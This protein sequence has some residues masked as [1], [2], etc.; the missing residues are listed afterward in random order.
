MRGHSRFQLRKT[1]ASFRRLRCLALLRQNCDFWD[2]LAAKC[3]VHREPVLLETGRTIRN[4][5][6]S[7]ICRVWATR[8]GG[9]CRLWPLGIVPAGP[10]RV[11]SVLG[12]RHPPA[13]ENLHGGRTTTD[14][15]GLISG[16]GRAGIRRVPHVK[17]RA[18]HAMPEDEKW[19]QV[20]WRRGNERAPGPA[21]CNHACA[22]PMERRSAQS[23]APAP[24]TWPARSR[25]A[26]SATKRIRE[27]LGLDRFERRGQHRRT[28]MTVMAY[29]LNADAPAGATQAH[30]LPV[31]TMT[32]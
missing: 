4:G 23:A 2:S 30:S 20:S 14:L 32:R 27:E 6:E 9:G 3:V 18:A 24:S 5:G 25:R 7:R 26:G 8:H 22:L 15:P 16:F 19:R 28:L 29:A 11:E 21:L 12:R 17:S 31:P 1:P 13:P 10:K